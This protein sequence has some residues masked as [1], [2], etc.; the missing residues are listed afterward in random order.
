[1][2]AILSSLH[3]LPIPQHYANIDQHCAMEPVVCFYRC[4]MP[5]QLYLRSNLNSWLSEVYIPATS[6]VIS[7]RYR[8]AIVHTHGDLT[9]LPYS[10]IRMPLR[11]IIL[12]VS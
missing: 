3:S 7:D 8:L 5:K 2:A 4:L 9:M 6:K 10:E 11:H 1:M 12:S